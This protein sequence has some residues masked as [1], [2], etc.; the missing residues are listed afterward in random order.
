M[1]ALRIA[2]FGFAVAGAVP[3]MAVVVA[4]PPVP[5]AA[6][7]AAYGINDAGVVAG[8]Y[9]DGQGSQHG[10][11]GTLDGKYTTFDAGTGGTSARAIDDRGVIVGFSNADSGDAAAQPIFE[12]KRNGDIVGVTRQG[13]QLFGAAYG[14]ESAKNRF[15]GFWWSSN[16]HQAIAFRGHDG[17]WK[18]DVRIHDVHQASAARGIN[19]HNVVVGGFFR[20]PMRGFVLQGRRLTVVDHPHASATELEAINDNGVATGQW[21]DRQG[22]T[23]AFLY[24]VATATF[25]DIGVKGASD[26]FAYG[27]NNKGDV[28]VTTDKGAYVWCA[29]RAACPSFAK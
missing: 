27:I 18:E 9:T 25:S 13:Q 12:R 17:T 6:S 11:F 24:D 19:A 26:V 23:H 4:V 15:V 1:V 28:A 10:F 3:A 29:T 5:G 16:L 8:T 7:T 22:H 2:L 20:P 21:V 14:I